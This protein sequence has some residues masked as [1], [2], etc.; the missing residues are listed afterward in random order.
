MNYKI[1]RNFTII[2]FIIG[3]ILIIYGTSNLPNEIPGYTSVYTNSDP[4]VI[5]QQQIDHQNKLRNYQIQT[6]EF[7]IIMGG[8]GV[9]C[10]WAICGYITFRKLIQME[11]ETEQKAERNERLRIARN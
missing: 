4:N 1:Y 11:I 2:T 8:I 10:M 5:N 7:K 9:M 3:I 6:V